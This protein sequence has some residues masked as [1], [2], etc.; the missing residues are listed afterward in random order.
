MDFKKNAGSEP[1]FLATSI[2]ETSLYKFWVVLLEHN[3]EIYQTPNDKNLKIHEPWL[4]LKAFCND[5]NIKILSMAFAQ[6]DFSKQLNL[7]HIA[8]G[9]F[10]SKRIQKQLPG[11]T[12]Y[13][14]G[15][16]ELSNNELKIHWIDDVTSDVQIENRK[17]NKNF[18][19]LG[20]ILNAKL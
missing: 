4:R 15:F 7:S 3:I 6:K 10:Y 11:N 8:D 17:I 13:S 20:L 14:Q 16:G 18:I 5:F 9:Y 12:Y 19:P 2:N 1:Y